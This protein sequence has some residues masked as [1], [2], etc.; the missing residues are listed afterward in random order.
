MQEKQTQILIVG[1]GTGGVAA[2]L[3]AL[4]LGARVIL[5]EETDWI[6]GQLTAQAVPP[7]E[8]PWI[9][10]RQTG[11]TASYRQFREGVRAYYRR[12]TPLQSEVSSD[13]FFN[14]GQGNVSPLCHEPRIG[15]AV[16]VEMLAPYVSNG[17]LEIHLSVKPIAAETDGDRVLSVTLQSIDDDQKMVIQAPYIIDATE[18]GDLLELAGVEHVI[19][20][21]SQAQTGEPSA[22]PGAPDPLDQQAH[23]WVFIVSY[24]PDEN[25]TIAKP[26]QYDF[27]RDY[28]AD[29]WSGKLLSWT[30]S[31]PM[32]LNPVTRPIFIEDTDAPHGTDLWH[33]RRILYRKFYPDGYHNS[34]AVVVNWPQIDYWLGPLVGVAPDDAA[35]H[36]QGS[37]ALSLSMLYW[38][39]TEAPRPDGGCGYPGLRLRGDLTGTSDGLAKAPYIRESRRLRAE[40]TVLEQHVGVLARGDLRGAEAFADTVGIGSYRIDLHPS[41]RR[42]YLDINNYPQQIPLGA[43]IPKRVENLLAGGKN[44]G[45][46]HITNGCYRLHPIE[47]NIGEAAGA[48]AAYCLHEQLQ[49]RQLRNTPALLAAFQDVLVNTLG[50][51]LAWPDDIRLTSREK[52]DPLGI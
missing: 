49:P 31:D 6:G 22:L 3:A 34:D 38:M 27:W 30:T 45:V 16:L 35:R 23:S 12:N 50:F 47:W 36:L 19:G 37:R 13:P 32:T 5:T 14:P 26:A 33:F 7:D 43:L 25:H 40:F 39:Q 42:N 20:A 52:Q 4:R 51:A 48:T 46:T 21:E 8:N 28:Q 15:L 9:D 24:H 44:L 10:R 18:L 41:Y 1:G 29:F 11:C 17:Q 2:A